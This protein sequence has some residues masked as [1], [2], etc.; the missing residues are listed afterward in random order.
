MRY[1]LFFRIDSTRTTKASAD[2]HAFGANFAIKISN[3]TSWRSRFLLKLA[4][5]LKPQL[6]E[7]LM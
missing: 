4:I 7:P 3:Q 5:N 6:V 1:A 2:L